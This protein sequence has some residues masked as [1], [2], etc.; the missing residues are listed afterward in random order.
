MLMIYAVFGSN[1]VVS[2]LAP[3][4]DIPVQR[5]IA[6]EGIQQRGNWNLPSGYDWN[7]PGIPGDDL[8]ESTYD[9][10][11]GGLGWLWDTT[12]NGFERQ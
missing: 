9:T 4:A 7:V 8:R 2:S 1:D 10:I 12:W 3:G 11:D 5:S 6:D